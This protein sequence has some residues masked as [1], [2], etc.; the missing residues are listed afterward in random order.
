MSVLV[1]GMEMPK[2]CMDCPFKGFDRAGGRG[3][4]CT[5]NESITLHAV[6]DGVD[7]KFVRMG[8]CPLVPVPPHGRLIDADA[9]PYL[10]G[11]TH[12]KAYDVVPRFMIDKMPT[13][14]EADGLDEVTDVGCKVCNTNCNEAGTDGEMCSAWTKKP[15]AEA[16]R[17]T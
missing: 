10:L 12:E 7:V 13:V 2:N 8:D 11:T 17:G 4:I 16:E 1:K 14:I 3:T 9:I 15:T 5:I 6:L